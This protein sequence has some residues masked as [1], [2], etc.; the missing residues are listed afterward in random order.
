MSIIVSIL[1]SLFIEHSVALCWDPDSDILLLHDLHCGL[2]C[3][4]ILDSDL[5]ISPASFS[6]SAVNHMILHCSSDFL[7]CLSDFK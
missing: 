5:L 3:T 1:L 4:V 7:H 6:N 2:F